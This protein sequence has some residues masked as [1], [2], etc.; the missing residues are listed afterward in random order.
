MR[1]L[2]LAIR[3]QL[4]ERQ[5]LCLLFFTRKVHPRG[6]LAADGDLLGYRGEG[7]ILAAIITSLLFFATIVLR[8]NPFCL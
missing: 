7:V 4:Q 3:K 8:R 1:L 2:C 5:C 6:I